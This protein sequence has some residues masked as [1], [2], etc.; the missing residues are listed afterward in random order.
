MSYQN[1]PTMP[2]SMAAGL[3]KSPVFNTVVQKVAAG[4]GNTSIS[5]KPFPTW[6][7]E[8]S[9]EHITGNEETAASTVAA[10]LGMF[11]SV[12]G[13]NGLW[14]FTDP[15]DSAVSYTNSAM[16]NV[17]AGAVSP[18]GLYGDGSSTQFQL[19]RSIGGVAWDILQNV[20][21]TGLK[22]NGSLKSLGTDY[23]VSSTGVVTF[24]SAPANGYTLTWAGTFQYLCRFKSDSVDALREFSKNSGTDNWSIS[25]IAFES[26]FI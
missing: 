14:T 3:K 15:Q 18:M 21:V 6:S 4:R 7:F 19:A 23:S 25:S 10:F 12:S 17:T 8:F 1:M 9:L 22:V 16:L 11:M 26:E 13:S 2:I 20:T 5:L 24:A